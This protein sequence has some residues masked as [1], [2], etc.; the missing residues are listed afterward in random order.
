MA[1]VSRGNLKSNVW[2]QAN[3]LPLG[4]WNISADLATNIPVLDRHSDTQTNRQASDIS[5]YTHEGLLMEECISVLGLLST[6]ARSVSSTSSPVPCQAS[7]SQISNLTSSSSP[8]PLP[9]C[10]NNRLTSTARSS[11]WIIFIFL[12]RIS[13]SF[14]GGWVPR[15]SLNLPVNGGTVRSVLWFCYSIW[16]L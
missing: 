6:L 4:Q 9:R 14:P 12:E 16:G 1:P 13:S 15:A 7:T 2:R 3:T 10:Q 5:I 11:R 8:R